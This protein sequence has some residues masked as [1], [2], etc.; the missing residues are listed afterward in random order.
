MT[1]EE[2]AIALAESSDYRVLRRLQ[3]RSVINP[4]DGD[5]NRVALFV[6][7]ETT[8]LD[9]RA[10]EIIELAMVPFTYAGDGRIYEVSAP[11][12]SFR[13]PTKPIPEAIT[14]ITGITDEMVEGASIDPAE[15]ASFADGAAPIIA[16]NAGFDRRFLERLDPAFMSK[17]W[18]CSQTQINWAAEGYEG[19]RLAYLAT[20]AGFFYEKH[21]VTADCYAGIEMLASTLPKSGALALSKLLEM[22]R[23]PSWR[24]WA[25][26]SPFETKDALKARGY[27]WHAARKCWHIAVYNTDEELTYLCQN[28]YRRD[29]ISLPIE[30]IT[31]FDRFSDRE[32]PA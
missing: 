20:G 5:G 26:G 10:D 31:A 15:V 28:I 8:G 16:H 27:Q 7:V 14:A 4:Y 2:M 19:T 1:L 9:P 17:P 23:A 25:M 29:A 3:P 32:V 12:H 21:Q 6:D 24:I 18:A 22:G 11:F 13:Q 30:K